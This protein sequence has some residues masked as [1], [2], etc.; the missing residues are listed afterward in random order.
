MAALASPDLL[1]PQ[2]FSTSRRF[3]PPVP[4]RAYCIPV[5]FMGFILF[6][7]FPPQEAEHLSTCHAPPD[8]PAE[9]MAFR[10][11]SNLAIRAYTLSP[12][13]E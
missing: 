6:R 2:V 11:L 8:L 7:G 9:A 12:V 3:D 4:F 1:R 10:G 13:K 5:P